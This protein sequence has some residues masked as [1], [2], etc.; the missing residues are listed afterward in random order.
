MENNNIARKY[1]YLFK[2]H[3]YVFHLLFPLIKRALQRMP[4]ITFKFHDFFNFHDI[5]A[6]ILF[7]A[8]IYSK[9]ILFHNVTCTARLSI[10]IID[11]H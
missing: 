9:N 5:N 10:T 3:K 11:E 2:L 7:S 1:W 8:K 6:L 4:I